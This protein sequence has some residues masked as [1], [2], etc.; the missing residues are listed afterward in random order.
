MTDVV[1]FAKELRAKRVAPALDSLERSI[2]KLDLVAADLYPW[3]E[4]ANTR[5]EF[6]DE[7][8]AHL[9]RV[10]NDCRTAARIARSALHKK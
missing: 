10:V 3:D 4:E 7:H 6:L 5:A 8:L 9:C 2:K 1:D